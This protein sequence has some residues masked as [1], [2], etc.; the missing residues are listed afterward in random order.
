MAVVDT[1]NAALVEHIVSQI[2]QNV[3][4]LASQNYISQA[5]AA[6]I[7]ERLPNERAAQSNG[8]ALSS[9]TSKFSNM[10]PSKGPSMPVPRAV[11]AAP[12][13]QQARAIWGYNEG[14]ADPNDLSFSSG[15][16]IDIIE[17]TNEDWWKGRF[18]G[19]E[20]LVPAN[21]VEK[22]R[23][24][25][26]GAPPASAPTPYRKF[27]AAYHGVDAPPPTGQGVNS[28]GLQEKPGTEEKKAGFGKYKDT[29]AQ[30][31]V[32]GAGFGAGAAI[33]GG[34]VRAIF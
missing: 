34:L 17:E 3:Q 5:D 6:T 11:P 14:G 1:Q 25:A 19:K 33:G 22:L 12:K 9:I 10:M 8:S 18:N 30:S 32:G 31:A 21:Y 13:V 16:I 27:G 20:G 26:P 23:T 28:V 15:D 24:V 29:L 7:L 4:F 2:E